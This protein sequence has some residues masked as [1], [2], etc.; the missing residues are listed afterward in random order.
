VT[1]VIATPSTETASSDLDPRRGESSLTAAHRIRVRLNAFQLLMRRWSTLH[2]YNAGQVMAVSGRPD[3]ERWKQAAQGVL[4]EMGLGPAAFEAGDR[5]ARFTTPEDVPVEESTADLTAFFNEELNRPFVAGDVPIRFRVL[6]AAAL[7]GDDDGSHYFAAVYDHWIADSRAMRELMHRI[8]E[9]YQAGGSGDGATLPPLTMEAPSFRS[10]FR[11]HVG[12]LVR[13][14]AL[15]QSAKN[16]WRHR[17]ACRINIPNPLDFH[18]Q[19]FIRQL[20]EGLIERVHEFAKTRGASVNDV[21]ITVLAQTMGVYTQDR[22]YRRRRRGFH[23]S[24]RDV[25]VG[26]IV[27]IRDAANATL[28]RVFNL[29]LSSYTVVLRDPEKRVVDAL[30]HEVAQETSRLKKT[31]ATVKGFW[32]LAMARLSWDL[33]R[34]P[35]NRALLLHKM[36]PVAAGISNVKMTGSWVDRPAGAQAAGDDSAQVLDYLRISPTGPLIPLVF[37]LTTIGKRLSLCATY[38]TTAFSDEDV[39]ALV[40]DFVHRLEKAVA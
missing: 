19:L 40:A 23:F 37:T 2:P 12:R 36:V 25:G 39:R 15:C 34:S 21:F 3:L 22:R 4:A 18:S 31:F 13:C 5:Y 24:R 8:F 28:D 7:T 16:I 9:R 30:T 33:C 20:P 29:Y 1:Q 17:R 32:A 10:L 27:D 26:T 35:R 11:K 6:P 38:R 14:M